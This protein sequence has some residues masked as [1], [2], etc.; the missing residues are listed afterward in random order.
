M[1]ENGKTVHKPDSVDAGNAALEQALRHNSAVF[2]AKLNTI[3]DHANDD[4]LRQDIADI[5]AKMLA[6]TA[7]LEGESSPIPAF[8]AGC[9]KDGLPQ[10]KLTC[11]L[12]A[13]APDLTRD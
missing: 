2:C 4:A 9:D 6:L 12:R 1:N 8:W 11:A 7:A 13:I 3:N 5:A 10:S